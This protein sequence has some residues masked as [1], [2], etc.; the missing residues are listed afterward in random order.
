ML[1]LALT[2]VQ[3]GGRQPLV[4]APCGHQELSDQ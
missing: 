3:I 1:E 4:R 2:A